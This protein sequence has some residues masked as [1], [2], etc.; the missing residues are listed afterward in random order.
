MD[1][2]MIKP[3]M[4]AKEYLQPMKKIIKKRED[5]KVWVHTATRVISK[6]ACSSLSLADR[7]YSSIS[8]DTKDEQTP[9]GRNPKGQNER[10]QV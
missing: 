2:K 4:D 1:A 10:M 7:A 8:N 9:P 6:R 5:R 3:L